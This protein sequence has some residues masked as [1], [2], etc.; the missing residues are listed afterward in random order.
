MAE[1]PYRRKLLDLHFRTG[2]AKPK[3]TV[4][5]HDDHRVVVTERTDDGG[6][7][8]DVLIVQDRPLSVR[9]SQEG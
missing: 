6:D 1:T 4:D 7:H 5:V 3:R 8:Q 9:T 2:P